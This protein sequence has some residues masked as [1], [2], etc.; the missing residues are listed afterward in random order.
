M[1]SP[2]PRVESSTVK[3]PIPR[4]LALRDSSL[5]SVSPEGVREGVENLFFLHPSGDGCHEVT[6]RGLSLAN[7]YYCS[8]N[9]TQ[10]L[11][12]SFD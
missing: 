12:N 10:V 2:D 6:E 1:N 5:Y 9:P 8:F 7:D 11:G 4:S 3:P